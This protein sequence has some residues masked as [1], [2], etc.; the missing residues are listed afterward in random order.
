MQIIL[1]GGK[2][3]I[4]YEGLEDISHDKIKFVHEYASEHINSENI[5]NFYIYNGKIF[6][7]EIEF[8]TEYDLYKLM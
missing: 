4:C 6:S 1:N 3:E 5:E 2:I 7:A 8:L